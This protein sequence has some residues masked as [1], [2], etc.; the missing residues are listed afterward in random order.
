[1]L[2]FLRKNSQVIARPPDQAYPTRQDQAEPDR[3]L[4]T[5]SSRFEATRSRLLDLSQ[6]APPPSGKPPG[7][8]GCLPASWRSHAGRSRIDR[9]P[10]GSRWPS[11][12]LRWRLISRAGCCYPARAPGL[13]RFRSSRGAPFSVKRA[14]SC[15]G[16]PIWGNTLSVLAYNRLPPINLAVRAYS[17]PAAGVRSVAFR[18]ICQ[19]PG[20]GWL[21]P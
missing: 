6:A 11:G 17:A 8:P 10:P 5:W 13:R 9:L 16:S 19:T 2:H 18:T 14:L 4:N 1:M 7:R 15:T 12:C 20:L 3:L 21:K